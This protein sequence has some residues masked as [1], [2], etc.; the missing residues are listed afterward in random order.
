MA[1]RPASIIALPPARWGLALL[2]VAFLV[3]G[4]FG[5]DPWKTDDAIGIGI[6]HSIFDR[7]AWLTLELAGEHYYEDGPLYYWFAAILAKGASFFMPVH[8]GARL[9]TLI[10][11]AT[12]LYFTRL[13]AREL[14]GKRAGDLSLLAL[15][16]SLG[17]LVHGHEVTAETAM[18]GA[19]AVAY[20]GIA[21]AWKKPIKAGI[22]FGLGTGCAFLAK[23]L[24]A[25]IPPLLAA[26]ILMPVAYVKGTR[27]FNYAVLLGVLILFPVAFIWPAAIA[28]VDPVY[29]AGWVAW[30]WNHIVG[31]P[32]LS[33]SIDYLKILAWAAWPAWPLAL[34]ATWE[35]R[36]NLANPRFATPLVASLVSVAMVITNQSSRELD[37]LAL[38]VPLAIPAGSAAMSLRRGAANALAWFSLMTFSLIAI[39][40]WLFWIASQTGFPPRM[41]AS[42]TRLEPGFLATFNAFAVSCAALFSIAWIWFVRRAELSTL[43]ALPFWAGGVILTW[44]LTMTLWIDWI[45]YGKTYR[46]VVESIAAYV[47]AEEGCLASRGLG[48]AQRAVFHY[49]GGILTRRAEID[50]GATCP[51]LLVQTTSIDSEEYPDIEWLRV[52]EGARPR[53]KERYWLFRRLD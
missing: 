5:H 4:L 29:F 45:D 48:E 23:G 9:A 39:A 50:R 21:I 51:Y 14:Y 37:A 40:I 1:A 49:H 53:D 41:A 32:S 38:L 36:G 17:L 42:V 13:A 43:R 27:S 2:A 8:D 28:I 20:Y 7:G 47:R 22:C 11:M 19:L 18:L 52:Y 24:I 31:A 30:Q 10:S 12:A 3:P 25:F 26:I 6:V 16:G 34:W 15:L 44:G 35:F 33:V 46:P